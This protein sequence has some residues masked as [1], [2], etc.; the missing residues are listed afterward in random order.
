MP[1]KLEIPENAGHL[2]PAIIIV[3]IARARLNIHGRGG[4]HVLHPELPITV[5]AVTTE[6]DK[7]W[8]G[9]QF[10]AVDARLCAARAAVVVVRHSVASH[11]K[12]GNHVVED[13]VAG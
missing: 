7:V 4:E 12:D 6:H 8:S 11:V 3:I 5:H 13:M 2:E 9:L 10:N 1:H